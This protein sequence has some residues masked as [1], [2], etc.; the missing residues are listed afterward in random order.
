MSRDFGG[1]D[2][3]RD[4]LERREVELARRVIKDEGAA[5]SIYTQIGGDDDKMHK[6][7]HILDAQD[8]REIT[9]MSRFVG[10]LALEKQFTR[11]YFE[12]ESDRASA[13]RPKGKSS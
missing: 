7:L 10:A 1:A 8:A 2:G 13:R 9:E 6:K 4:R 3:K 12:N 5:I 11:Y